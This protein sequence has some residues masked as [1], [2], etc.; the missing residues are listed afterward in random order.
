[1]K[2]ESSDAKAPIINAKKVFRRI[3]TIKKIIERDNLTDIHFW[4][5]FRKEF[6]NFIENDFKINKMKADELRVML[7]KRKIWMQTKRITIVKAF[8]NTLKKEE[9][10]QWSQKKI[11]R[12][13]LRKQFVSKKLS[14]YVF[15]ININKTSRT[16]GENRRSSILWSSNT[17]NSQHHERAIISKQSEHQQS[18]HQQ[19]QQSKQSKHQNENQSEQQTEQQ[20]Q[21]NEK[22]R[23]HTEQFQKIQ[24]QQSRMQSI[25]QQSFLFDEISFWAP[26]V[27]SKS[28]I[29]RTSKNHDRVLF[30]LIKMYSNETKYN[31]END[32]W[33]FKFIIFHDMC[34]KTEVFETAKLMTLSIM[35]KNFALNYYYFNVTVWR[36]ALN[37]VQAC[38]SINSYF[39]NAEYKRNVMTKWNVIIFRSVMTTSKHQNKLMNECLQLLIKKLRHL[40]HDLNEEFRIDKFIHNKLIIACQDVSACQYTCYKSSNDLIGLI[41][42]LQSFI[43]IF[44]KSHSHQIENYQSKTAYYIDRCYCINYFKRQSQL[45]FRSRSKSDHSNEPRTLYDREKNNF[46]RTIVSYNSKQYDRRKKR[47]FICNKTDCW[48]INHTWKK[49][50]ASKTRLKKRFNESF[51]R[52]DHQSEKDWNKQMFQYMIDYICNHESIDFDAE[53]VDEMNAFIMKID[54]S[55]AQVVI[56]QQ[57]FYET[58]WQSAWA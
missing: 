32:S 19:S 10:V 5:A 42:D 18:K 29:F 41:N 8:I 38:V 50:D 46:D 37:F 15:Q 11:N 13:Y 44:N 45:R 27:S 54:V 12:I 2:S 4:T 40:Q 16:S 52:S 1:M 57:L 51:N 14:N 20:R 3:R 33:N 47:C 24:S 56:N 31:D 9:Q 55:K 21:Q 58:N 39:E 28:S 7:K 34:A 35:F 48:S 6:E 43:I 25:E 30:N 53:F 22:Q 17:S 26:S 23:Q 49:R 36:S